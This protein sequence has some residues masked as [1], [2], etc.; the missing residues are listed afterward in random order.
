[1]LCLYKRSVCVLLTT[2]DLVRGGV[3]T[4]IAVTVADERGADAAAVGTGEL[5]YGVA[6]GE[7]APALITVVPA[8]VCVVTLVGVGHAAPIITG[9][10]HRGA[11]VE[12]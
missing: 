11:G 1:M 7:R 2:V 10:A 9:E 8:V 5:I 3:V 4:A 12:R 6:G